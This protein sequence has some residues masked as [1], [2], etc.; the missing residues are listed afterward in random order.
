M[1]KIDESNKHVDKLRIE[2]VKFN[3]KILDLSICREKFT[4][5][6]KNLNLLFGSQRFVY[7]HAEIGYNPLKK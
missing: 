4:K 6:Q 3:A 5:W 7:D 2:N 1:I